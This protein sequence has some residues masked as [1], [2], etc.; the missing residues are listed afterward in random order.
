M[1]RLQAGNRQLSKHLFLR[2]LDTTISVRF[3]GDVFAVCR[4]RST[5][6]YEIPCFD[7]D[8]VKFYV[9]S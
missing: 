5:I 3:D 4:N 7:I 6:F 8:V 1:S 2:C 9:A